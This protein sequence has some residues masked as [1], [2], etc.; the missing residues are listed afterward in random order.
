MFVHYG[1]NDGTSQIYFL[2]LVHGHWDIKLPDVD[3]AVT[4]S[5]PKESV[6]TGIAIVVPAKKILETIYHPELVR[7]R[8]EEMKKKNAKNLPVEDSIENDK[9]ITEGDGFTKD[10]F[11]D[12]LKKSSTPTQPDPK[13]KGT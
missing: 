5:T 2:G 6:N 4:N 12:A 13:K 3:E 7:L 8:E 10:D 9:E 11:M 1:R